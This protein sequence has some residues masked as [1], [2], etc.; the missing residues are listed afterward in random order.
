MSARSASPR[1]VLV[2]VVSV[3]ALLLLT[4]CGKKTAPAVSSEPAKPQTAAALPVSSPEEP[5]AA[6]GSIDFPQ[7][8]GRRTGDLDEMAKSRNIRA[9]VLLNPIGFFYDKGHPQGVMYEALEEFQKFVNQKLK[10]GT[11]NLRVTFF[12]LRPDQIEAALTEGV[13]DMIAYGLVVTP[14]REQRVA[15]S[16]PIQTNV[17]QIVVTGPDF[18]PVS[19]LADLSGKE[20]YANPLSTY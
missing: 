19:S 1:Q 3:F 15:F 11:L 16:T 14:E 10:P 4:A 12:P 13:G 7:A 20:V 5:P 6:S 8:F 2:L 9:L 17:T 18:G